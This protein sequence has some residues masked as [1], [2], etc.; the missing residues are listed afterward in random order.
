MVLERQLGVVTI[1]C[2]ISMLLW[3]SLDP[4]FLKSQMGVL[5][6]EQ[7]ILS[8]RTALGKFL[9]VYPQEK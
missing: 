3:P 1:K 7:F 5:Y 8:L 4:L 6:L 9:N 2:L